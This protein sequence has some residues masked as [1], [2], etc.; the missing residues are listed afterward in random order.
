MWLICSH[1]AGGGNVFSAS[2]SLCECQIMS[3]YDHPVTD[4]KNFEHDNHI[5]VF[6][7]ILFLPALLFLSPIFFPLPLL[8]LLPF[9]FAAGIDVGA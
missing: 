8:L 5:T 7:L 4:M 3:D 6:S 1:L 9:A 2:L